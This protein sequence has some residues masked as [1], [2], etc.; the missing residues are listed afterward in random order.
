MGRTEFLNLKTIASQPWLG[1]VQNLNESE[2]AL[3]GVLRLPSFEIYLTQPTL[4]ERRFSAKN[5]SLIPIRAFAGI[6]R[7]WWRRRFEQRTLLPSRDLIDNSN[8]YPS[9]KS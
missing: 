2:M 4:S 1:M 5:C 8:S 9:I 7:W 6:R 3:L